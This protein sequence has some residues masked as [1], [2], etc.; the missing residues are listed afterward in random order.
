LS[1]RDLPLWA[2]GAAAGLVL[3]AAWWLLSTAALRN[4]VGESLGALCLGVISLSILRGMHLPLSIWPDGPWRA[5]FSTVAVI[6]VATVFAGLMIISGRNPPPAL[7]VR[8]DPGMFALVVA[9][10]IFWGF[11][12]GFVRQRTFAPWYMLAILVGLLP[13]VVSLIFDSGE[14]G[15]VCVWSIREID[16]SGTTEGCQAALLPALLF[17]VPIG[18][19]A[20]LV[21]EELTFRRVLMGQPST[22]GLAH[23]VGSSAVAV[24]WFALL[25]WTG[26]S[27]SD[28][29]ILGTF[30]A[31]SAG[32]LYSLS[33]SLLVSGLYSATISAG[34]WSLRLSQVDGT[35]GT[36]A[37]VPTSLWVSGS[38]TAIVL[39]A[40]LVKRN[41]L[42]G[43]I[44]DRRKRN[45]PGH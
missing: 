21:T 22:A 8:L 17:L 32:C 33:G 40:L 3:F 38:L 5:R 31:I 1:Q 11:S 18:A 41:G 4:A 34:H 16:Q 43:R 27:V 9:G 12:F 25:M 14:W 23:V 36:A 37:T 6:V 42:L 2:R 19:A 24:L 10:A 29:V 13:L 20:K 39:A 30:G 28:S 15:N 35:P 7:E 44:G 26:V 45:A